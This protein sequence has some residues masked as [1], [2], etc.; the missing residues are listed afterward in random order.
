MTT[1]SYQRAFGH[2]TA[3]D[4]TDL[5]YNYRMDDIRASLGVVQLDKLR[6]DLEADTDQ[7]MVLCAA[8]ETG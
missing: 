3:Y 6:E 8:H 2:A 5:G 4:I 1:M 7:G